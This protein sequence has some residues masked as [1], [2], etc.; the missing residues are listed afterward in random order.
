MGSED[1]VAAARV[2]LHAPVELTEGRLRRL[3]EGIGKVVYASKHWVVKR[4][5]SPSE[6]VALILLWRWVRRAETVLPGGLSRRLLRHPGPQIR[7]LRVAVQGVMRVAP[8]G[9]WLSEHVRDVW[10]AYRVNDRRGERLAREHLTG[11]PLVPEV[12]EF[13][14]VRVKIGGWPGWLT[15][16]EATARVENTL[17]RALR[18]LAGEGRYDEVESLLEQFLEV[19]Q[20]GWSLGL[21]SLDAHLK[22]FGV[23]NG[24]IVLLD[25]G[26]LTD[27]WEDVAERLV[28]EEVVTEPHVQLGL[29]DVL[30]GRPD[31]AAAFNSR[32]RETVNAETVK[33]HWEGDSGQSE[34]GFGPNP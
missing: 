30:A 16:S 23:A 1:F 2:L 20:Q 31:L 19:R 3:G 18:E 27:R 9:L 28:F 8:R 34:N 10:K 26:G 25:A 29:A 7:L 13:P 32:W 4:P 14:P 5:R 17:D 22:N 24:K 11:T 33:R 6:V 21:F 15:V 12:I